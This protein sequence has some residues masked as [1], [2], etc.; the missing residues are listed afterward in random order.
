[1]KL[2]LTRIASVLAMLAFTGAAQTAAPSFISG[3]R[4][5]VCMDPSFAPMEF[6]ETAGQ[7]P[8]GFDVDLTNLLAKAWNVNPTSSPWSSA[9]CYRASTPSAAIH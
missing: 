9:G 5:N 2:Y 6:V 4:W 3:D 7:E 8:V 1:M